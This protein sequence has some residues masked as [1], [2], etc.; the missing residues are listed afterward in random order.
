MASRSDQK[1]GDAGALGDHPL[2]VLTVTRYDIVS[3]F[4]GAVVIGLIVAVVWLGVLWATN[5]VSRPDSEV[6]VE[7]LELAGGVEDGA[8]NETLDVESPDPET[9]DPSLADIPAEETEI[10]EILENV[11]ELSDEA[12]TLAPQQFELGARNAG[13]PG[14]ATGTG[15]RPLGIGPGEGGLPREQ[16]WF[17]RFSDRGTL[18]EYARQLDFFGIELGA[19]MPGGKLILLSNLTAEKPTSRTVTSGAGENRLYMTWQGGERRKADFDLFR[20]AG[21]D[22]SR[23]IILHFYPPRTERLLATL[24]RTYRN[25]PVERIRRTY[26][27]VRREGR[28]YR[29]A[30]TR[31]IYFQ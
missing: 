10:Q 30:V 29:F 31:Q 18:E 6:P 12:A 19:L 15:R 9:A 11:V 17:V 16:R 13:K 3:S 20:K 22:A 1:R 5:R 23:A 27:V 2:P 7:L 24:E 28:G 25:Q 26:F 8:V 4:L 14:S 21:I